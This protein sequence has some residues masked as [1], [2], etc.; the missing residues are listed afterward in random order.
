MGGLGAWLATW[1]GNRRALDALMTALT[2][3]FAIKCM[4]PPSRGCHVCIAEL[5]QVDETCA[6]ISKYLRHMH[7]FVSVCSLRLV[8]I[9]WILTPALFCAKCKFMV[10]KHWAA[11]AHQA[12]NL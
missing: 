2:D 5:T 10:A 4:F 1:A 3:A 7:Q 9:P 8:R 11:D 12:A 6:G